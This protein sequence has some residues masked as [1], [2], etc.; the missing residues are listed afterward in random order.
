M[1]RRAELEGNLRRKPNPKGAQAGARKRSEESEE[2][3]VAGKRAMTVERR[4]SACKRKA[5][6]I[7][8]RNILPE[9]AVKGGNPQMMRRAANRL[10]KLNDAVVTKVKRY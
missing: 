2:A 5:K 9:R 6:D 3:I 8:I 4:A 1:H 7:R 10:S